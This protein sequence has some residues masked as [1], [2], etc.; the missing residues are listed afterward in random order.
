MRSTAEAGLYIPLA[1]T[2]KASGS[3]AV[4]VVEAGMC[5]LLGLRMMASGKTKNKRGM[6]ELYRKGKEVWRD[7]SVYEGDY[8]NG[9]K[10]GFGVFTW[11]DG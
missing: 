1:T 8:K 4:L 3:I 9:L 5:R 7:G 2:T 10:E 11:A 6:L